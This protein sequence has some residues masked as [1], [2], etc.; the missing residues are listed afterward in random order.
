MFFSSRFAAAILAQ[1]PTGVLLSSYPLAGLPQPDFGQALKQDAG[2]RLFSCLVSLGEAIKDLRT[3]RSSWPAVNL[4]YSCFYA[5]EAQLASDQV[6]IFFHSHNYYVADS[7]VGTI[8]KVGT[9]SHSLNWNAIQSLTRLNR[10]SYQD[11]SEDAYETMKKFREEANYQSPFQDPNS[12][13]ELKNLNISRIE[14]AF[15][16]YK[17]DNEQFYTFLA[18]HVALA[19]PVKM[20]QEAWIATQ[21]FGVRLSEEQYDHLRALWPFSTDLIVRVP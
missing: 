10:W 14:R 8:K 20:A 12:R 1:K 16:Q 4:Y 7:I 9:S 5:L 18:D 21:A 15:R 2:A 3:S 17:E 6:T 19:Y 11:Q 13:R